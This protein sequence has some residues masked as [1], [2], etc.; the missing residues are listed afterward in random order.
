M[1]LEPEMELWL[2]PTLSEKN[3]LPLEPGKVDEQPID[4]VCDSRSGHGLRPDGEGRDDN[5]GGNERGR[6][7][8]GIIV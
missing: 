3:S 4:E 2:M 7:V 6:L 8:G 5:C 1:L